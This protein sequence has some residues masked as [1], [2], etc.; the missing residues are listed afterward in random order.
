MKGEEEY[1]NMKMK[2]IYTKIYERYRSRCLDKASNIGA[3]I[4]RRELEA[5]KTQELF[6]K[7]MVAIKKR[8]AKSQI[9]KKLKETCKEGANQRVEN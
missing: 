9:E 3:I 8:N 4:M 6:L 2:E 7:L 5:K 1:L